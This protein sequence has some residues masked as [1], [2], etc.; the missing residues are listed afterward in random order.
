[1]ITVDNF[2]ISPEPFIQKCRS[3]ARARNLFLDVVDGRVRLAWTVSSDDGRVEFMERAD[4][5]GLGIGYDTLLDALSEAGGAIDENG[6]YPIN[7]AIRQ[8]LNRIF[9]VIGKMA[10]ICI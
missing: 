6:C 3:L 9:I 2:V 1:V 5:I 4:A 8:R 10:G 7:D